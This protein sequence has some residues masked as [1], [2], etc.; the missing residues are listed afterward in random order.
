M[1]VKQTET[2]TNKEAMKAIEENVLTIQQGMEAKMDT[3]MEVGK[4][5]MMSY[6]QRA[7]AYQKEMWAELKPA[8]KK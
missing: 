1:D 4:D 2:E 8:K 6:H 5:M 7:E 3:A